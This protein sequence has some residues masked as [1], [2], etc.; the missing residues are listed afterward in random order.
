MVPRS[1]S[2]CAICGSLLRFTVRPK[3][4]TRMAGKIF[5]L[6]P[7]D[8]ASGKIFGK[9]TRF[10]AVKSQSGNRKKGSA[11][12]G[13]RNLIDHPVSQHELDIRSTF[14]IGT[15]LVA[16]RL[17]QT[18]PRWEAD[19]NLYK[20]QKEYESFKKWLWAQVKANPVGIDFLVYGG[21]PF[22]PGGEKL[23]MDAAN[24]K[25]LTLAL[26]PG[27]AEV[28]TGDV[29]VNVNGTALTGVSVEDE[30]LTA[31]LPA[32]LDAREVMVDAVIAS[33]SPPS[34]ETVKVH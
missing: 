10:C 19:H 27:T 12:L 8:N 18:S 2:I 34:F 25:T 23:I 7:I 9:K 16:P 20:Q 6:A 32:S 31:P 33:I 29:Q 11:Y 14:S 5:Y 17:K 15:R 24:K 21:K 3:C 22:Y 30:M 26:V 1:E 28:L 4:R 13:E